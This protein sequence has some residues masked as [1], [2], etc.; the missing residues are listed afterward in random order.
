MIDPTWSLY[1]EEKRRDLLREAEKSRR[2]KALRSAASDRSRS[3][4]ACDPGGL[5][6]MWKQLLAAILGH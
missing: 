3:R 5:E 6:R 1:S 2:L 4:L